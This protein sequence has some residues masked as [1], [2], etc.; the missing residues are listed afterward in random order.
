MCVS[1]SP[2]KHALLL[3]LMWRPFN[4]EVKQD[5][6]GSYIELWAKNG[7]IILTTTHVYSSHFKNNYFFVFFVHF[8]GLSYRKY[9]FLDDRA[10]SHIEIESL[11]HATTH[12]QF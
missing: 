3:I 9:H 8:F 2:K 4:D 7:S 6:F 1:A 5:I 12:L 10:T 11:S